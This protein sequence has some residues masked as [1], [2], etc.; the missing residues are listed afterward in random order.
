M[1]RSFF[2]FESEEEEM[3]EFSRHQARRSKVIPIK[4]NVRTSAINIKKPRSINDARDGADEL[5]EGRVV[6]M[7][8]SGV[9]KDLAKEI[10]YFLSG[11]SYALGGEYKKVGNEIFLFTPDNV[12]VSLLDDIQDKHATQNSLG[13]DEI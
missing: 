12:A 8:L 6:I 9:E 13:F 3:D 1:V 10:V 2:S 5:R 11:T 4:G 7:N